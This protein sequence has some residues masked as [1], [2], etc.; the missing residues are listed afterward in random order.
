[1]DD[2]APVRPFE[3]LCDLGVLRG[4]CGSEEREPPATDVPE[5]AWPQDDTHDRHTG[6]RQHSHRDR[7]LAVRDP[8]LGHRHDDEICEQG[9]I[10]VQVSRRDGGILMRSDHEDASIG[11]DRGQGC[12]APVE[13]DQ[14]GIEL[15]GET[16]ARED[17]GRA[18]G[19]CETAAATA[20]AD[21][22]HAGQCR[23]LEVIR[24]GVKARARDAEQVSDGR[25]HLDE[26]GLGRPPAT[27]R[28]DDDVPLLR[29]LC[30]PRAR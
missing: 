3:V 20:A 10:R 22:R 28:N 16:D 27:H 30:S 4:R 18:D 23:G 17:V 13:H 6:A 7:E 8:I 26:L 5:G 14:V 9:A 29:Q 12:S 15:L 1:M 2:L 25:S 24:C 11:C 19:T 21:R